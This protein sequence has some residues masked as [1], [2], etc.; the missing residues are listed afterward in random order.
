MRWRSGEAARVSGA[1]KSRW[2]RQVVVGMWVRV[3]GSGREE[4]GTGGGREAAGIGGGAEGVGGG[5]GGGAVIGGRRRRGAFW[6]GSCGSVFRV[7]SGGCARVG[8]AGVGLRGGRGGILR[9]G[10]GGRSAIEVNAGGSVRPLAE[11]FGSG[12]F[13]GGGFDATAGGGGGG[14]TPAFAGG[15]VW[16][17]RAGSGGTV[18]GARDGGGGGGGLARVGGRAGGDGSELCCSLSSA[19]RARTEGTAAESTDI[20]SV[21]NAVGVVQSLWEACEMLRAE[22]IDISTQEGPSFLESFAFRC[23]ET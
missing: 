20:C 10:S 3:V 23:L 13:G 12:G 7:G 2:W 18:E 19:S 14:R 9:G 17:R 6:V 16:V 5:S 21:R 4:R 22:G 15:A 11:R 1:V 8:S